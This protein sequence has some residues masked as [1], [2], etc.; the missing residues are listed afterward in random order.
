MFFDILSLVNL[1]QL[2]ITVENLGNDLNAVAYE[3]IETGL[4]FD[5]SVILSN[6]LRRVFT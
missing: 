4:Q 2:D 1:V 5:A 6:T 3:T